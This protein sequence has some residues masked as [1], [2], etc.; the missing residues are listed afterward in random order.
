MIDGARTLQEELGMSF[1]LDRISGPWTS[2]TIDPNLEIDESDLDRLKEL[3]DGVVPPYIQNL[4]SLPNLN[5]TDA[6][7]PWS[8]AAAAKTSNIDTTRFCITTVISATEHL[9]RQVA[10]KQLESQKARTQIKNSIELSAA[11]PH[12]SASD[13]EVAISTELRQKLETFQTNYGVPL[14]TEKEKTLT[15]AL[16]SKIRGLLTDMND[17][18]KRDINDLMM[19]DLQNIIQDIKTLLEQATT[20]SRRQ[21]EFNRKISNNMRS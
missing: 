15:E 12:L 8:V 2:P 13:K 5:Q 6:A 7:S 18:A 10:A 21:E 1:D 11:L 17:D 9:T 16:V 14:I 19:I 20:A 3:V 4:S